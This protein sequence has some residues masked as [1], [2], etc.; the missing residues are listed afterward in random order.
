MKIEELIKAKKEKWKNFL[1]GTGD[2][3]L[4]IVRV[5]DELIT[6]KAVNINYAKFAPGNEKILI[7]ESIQR[8][9]THCERAK[10]IDD[11]FIP[12]LDCHSGTEIFAET[13]GCE[14]ERPND[15]MPFAKPL[16]FS[17]SEAD[18]IR[19]VKLAETSLSRFFDI[20]DELRRRCGYFIPLKPVD[21]QSPIDIS[22]LIWEK[23][24][25][26]IG[27]MEA[28]DSVR[29][30]ACKAR[31]LVVEFCD[32]W[33]ARYG[34]DFI[35]HY[36]DYYM[37]NGITLSEDECGN[38]NPEIFDELVLEHLNF[39]SERY[40]GIGI[41]CCADSRHQWENFR[42]V[43]N[44]RVLNF[45]C[46]P[47]RKG[48]EFIVEALKFFEKKCVQYHYGWQP[49]CEYE[50]MPENYPIRRQLVIDI[51]VNSIEEARKACYS[52]RKAQEKMLT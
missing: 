16:V 52:L 27:M 34:K 45:V 32:E 49:A 38:F 19:A 43:K 10:I 20:A 15:N 29:A 22:A 30:L 36:P 26:L 46:P 6:N 47:T 39:L 35:S 5:P 31:N 18:K 7:E 24:D 28:P 44:L 42:K 37:E 13:F 21:V 8:F 25:F 50:L 51:T 48:D 12:F 33:F 23:T 9:Q 3:F 4:F 41:H 1:H 40:G 17:A 14:A 11:D 2:A